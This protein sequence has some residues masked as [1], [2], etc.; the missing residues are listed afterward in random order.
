[1][2]S[3][4]DLDRSP[5]DYLAILDN[6]RAACHGDERDFVAVWNPYLPYHKASSRAY[7][8]GPGTFG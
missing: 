6:R 3:R 5:A 4:G 2:V 7:Q 1:M 8:G